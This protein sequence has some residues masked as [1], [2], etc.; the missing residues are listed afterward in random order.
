MPIDF[1]KDVEPS[2]VYDYE[3]DAQSMNDLSKFNVFVGLPK[4][5]DIGWSSVNVVDM[6]VDYETKTDILNF[7]ETSL[8]EF[9][10]LLFQL[11]EYYK[12]PSQLIYSYLLDVENNVIDE[13]VN[14]NLSVE[15]MV[16]ENYNFNVSILPKPNTVWDVLVDYSWNVSFVLQ[17]FKM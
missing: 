11:S 4:T 16:W 13:E 12:L 7:A 10:E 2:F 17:L 8:E 14:I 6:F 9:N 3:I 1:L 5:P 15:K